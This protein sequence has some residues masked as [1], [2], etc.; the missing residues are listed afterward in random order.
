MAMSG[1]LLSVLHPGIPMKYRSHITLLLFATVITLSTTGR[2]QDKVYRLGVPKDHRAPAYGK[3]F[4][5][6]ETRKF[7]IGHNLQI[8]PI[9]LSDFQSET[10]K[11]RIRRDIAR[12]CDLFFSTGDHL[13]IIIGVQIRTP[14]LFVSIKG[15]MHELP[16]TMQEN[17]TGVY[18]GT[19]ANLFLQSARML[20]T[21]QRQKLGLIYF[22]GSQLATL[23]PQYQDLCQELGMD[24]VVKEFNGRGDIEG[25]MREFKAEGVQGLVLFPPAARP[26]ELSDLIT[27]QN[28]LKLPIL[29]QVNEQIE[30]GLLGGPTVDYNIL[31]PIL[32]DYAVKIL[33]GRNPGQ[34]PIRYVSDAYVVNLAAVSTLGITIPPEVIEEA[35]IVG[36]ASRPKPRKVESK[37]LVAG[38]YTIAMPEG[39][40][41]PTRDSILYAL[42][43]RGYVEGSNLHLIMYDLIGRNDPQQQRQTSDLLAGADVIVAAGFILPSLIRL[44]GLQKPVCFIAT[45]ETAAI[46]P[47]D[48]KNHFTGVIRASMNSAIAMSQMMML[49]AKRMGILG[50]TDSNLQRLVGRY[51]Q[52]ADQYG[53][54]IEYR[55]FT[56]RE[57]IGPAMQELKRTNDFILLFPPSISDDDLAEIIIWQNRLHLPVLSQFKNHIEAGL[58]GGPV[59]DFGK[60]TPKV[61]EY[62]DKLLQGRHPASL[63]IYY[64]QEKYV[65][66]LRTAALIHLEIPEEITR[67]AEIIR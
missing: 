57:E 66:N 35:Q 38:K 43:K 30:E 55:L 22:R 23:A 25:V 48:L 47:V 5:A 53:I 28:W 29:G 44:P 14:L 45:K 61:V 13:G 21:D 52:V 33:H 36:L 16:P 7:F 24:L 49:G 2:A 63:P 17:A 4:A 15:P 31:A 10:G 54:T 56:A 34:L 41:L 9:D 11:A 12:K 62:L 3:L 67:Q 64:Y 27:W 40:P 46:I 50:H 65:I 42:S 51:Q 39:L 26:E 32:A 18:R 20:P 58:L 8:V 60:V 6:L 59:E 19:T 1:F 37:P